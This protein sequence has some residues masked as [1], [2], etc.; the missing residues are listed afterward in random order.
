M[1]TLFNELA[2]LLKQDARFWAD[3]QLLKNQVMEHALKLDKGLVRLL[4]SHP[5]LKEHFFTDVDGVLIFDKEKFIRFISNKAFLPDSYT[6]FKNKIGLM[7]EDGRYLSESREVVL[8]WPY[9]D[10]VLEGGQTK[11]D[12]KRDEIFWNTILA[13]D[14]IDRLFE[15]KV[16]TNWKRYD[17][18][19]VS[20]IVGRNENAPNSDVGRIENAPNSPVGRIENAPNNPVGRNENAPNSDVGRIE[21][22]PNSPVGRIENAPNSPVGRIGNPTYRDA[23]WID[24]DRE[25]LIIKG[26]NLLA[27]HSLKKRFAGKVKLIY[28][29]PPFNTRKPDDSFKYNDK[30]NHSTWLTF[31]RNRLEV[32]KI[33]LRK[34]GL[35]FVHLDGNEMAYGKVLMD[36]VFGRENYRNTITLTTNEPSGFKATSGKVFSTA[37]YILVYTK[38]KSHGSLKKIY[39]EAEYDPMYHWVLEDRAKP[40][41][42]WR[43]IDIGEAVA[44]EQRFTSK[45]EAK[46]KLGTLFGRM[47]ADYAIKNAQR[48]FRTAAIRGGARKKRLKTI[49]Q[50]MRERNK[51]FVYPGEDVPDF[52]I[53]N[54][55]QILFYENR[56]IEIDGDKVPGRLITDVWTDISWTGIANEGG[57][58]LK[59]GKKPE[60]LL[61]RII[62]MTTEE[63]DIVLDFFLGS[64]TTAAIAHKMGRQYIGIEQMDYGENDSVVRLKNVIQGDPTGIS[65]AVN[66]QGGGSF[67]YCELMQWNE[68]FVERIQAARDKETLQTIWEEMQEK[69]HLSHRVDVSRI[70]NAANDFAALSLKD[71]KRFLLE[72]LDANQLYVNL[73]EIDDET[74][75]VSE[76][77]K[78][79]NRA[80]Y[81]RSD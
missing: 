38:E 77:D 11:E 55:E 34:D 57:V 56:L 72:T 49:E 41:E 2:A 44:M 76:E 60:K 39:I 21:N 8:A 37:N 78:R 14:E 27:L 50:S 7:T 67:I 20:Q 75:G 42:Q 3:D 1:K 4:L 61:A 36:E 71:Q 12:Q 73:S 26:N 69:A 33:L 43:W 48:V 51:V 5:R 65:K 64:G 59:N 53:L 32:A 29:D 70:D 40:I 68:R 45:K 30:F 54:G 58:K 13:P 19:G 79:L 28:I 15:P 10:C 17:A 23:R 47:V 31:M 81:S 63:S 52:Y 6:S 62:E 22:A 35:I 80:F 66:W 16:L 46:K 24:F 25:N 9:K 74:Y 18:N